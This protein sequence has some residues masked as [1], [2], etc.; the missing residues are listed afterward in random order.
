MERLQ[1]LIDVLDD[2]SVVLRSQSARG[3]NIC[4]ICGRPAKGFRTPFA[5]LEYSISCICQQ[6]QDYYFLGDGD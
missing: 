6:C 3:R 4:K 1:E 2:E 5:R